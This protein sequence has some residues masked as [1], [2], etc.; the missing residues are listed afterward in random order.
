[1]WWV[2][3]GPND[4][5]ESYW[6]YDS[7]RQFRSHRCQYRDADRFPVLYSQ[8]GQ[9]PSRAQINHVWFNYIKKFGPP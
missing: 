2:I 4:Y 7:I 3:L 1:M 6:Q 5:H 8:I 9:L